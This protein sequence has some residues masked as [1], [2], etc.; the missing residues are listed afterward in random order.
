METLKS[1]QSAGY[2][3]RQW[4]G[5]LQ[6]KLNYRLVF[7]RE[8]DM[9]AEV[10]TKKSNTE[11]RNSSYKWVLTGVI[12]RAIYAQ[13]QIVKNRA[14]SWKL[15]KFNSWVWSQGKRGK[16]LYQNHCHFSIIMGIPKTAL[17]LRSNTRGLIPCKGVVRRGDIT[18][19]I[20]PD[21]KQIST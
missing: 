8:M 17:F 11:F 16:P 21:P 19:I 9:T 2:G 4:G 7:R 20:Q 15:V 13:A 3:E 1:H 12:Y 6:H 10:R 14:I 18:E 5:D